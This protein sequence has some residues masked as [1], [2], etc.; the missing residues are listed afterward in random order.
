[1]LHRFP[2]AVGD[3]VL[4]DRGYCS[5][6]GILYAAAE[7]KAHLMVRCKLQLPFEDSSGAPFIMLDHLGA[8]DH[9]GVT[10]SWPVNVRGTGGQTVAGRLCAI[11]KSETAIFQAH[12]RLRERASRKQHELRPE[13]LEMAKYVTVFTTFPEARFS[14]VDVLDWYRVRWQ[15]ELVFKRFKSIAQLG[16]LPKHDP[17]SSKAWL[18]GKLFLALATERV[19]RLASDFFPWG[20]TL[21]APPPSQ[22]LA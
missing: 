2:I 14:S 10:G 6:A 20:Y 8:V 3:Y 18:Y 17:E 4:A 21:S 11:R 13:T 16:H 7:C 19:I 1:M 5:A 9:A 12:K 22:P 15:I